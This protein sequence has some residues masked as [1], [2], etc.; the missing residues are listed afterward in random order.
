MQKESEKDS[1]WTFLPHLLDIRVVREARL[2]RDGCSK[3][4]YLHF[5]S[6][7]TLYF[8]SSISKISIISHASFPYVLIAR[9]ICI[10][11]VHRF[12]RTSIGFTE[13]SRILINERYTGDSFITVTVPGKKRRSDG[14]CSRAITRF[15]RRYSPRWNSVKTVTSLVID[16]IDHTLIEFRS[17]K[18]GSRWRASRVYYYLFNAIETQVSLSRRGL[19]SCA[20]KV[21]NDTN[22]TSRSLTLSSPW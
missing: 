4:A 16:S 1:L 7:I 19:P 6:E 21:E 14:K 12:H 11:I 18:L 15:N 3:Y 22:T 10:P 17:E 8:S 20:S 5:R 13:L 2:A 9:E